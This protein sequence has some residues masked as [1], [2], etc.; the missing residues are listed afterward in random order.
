M[1]KSFAQIFLGGLIVVFCLAGAAR[2]VAA[3]QLQQARVSQV[4]QDVRLM[5][6]HGAPRPAAVNDT[7]T[8]RM[9]VRTGVES[10]AELTFTDLTLTRLGANTI[11]SFKQGARELDLTS[12]AVLLEVPPKAPAVK[13][14]TSAVTAAV[15]G[16]TALFATGPPT[17]FMVLEG[18]GT[19]Y[20]KGHPERAVIVHGGEMMMMTSEGRMTKPQKFD[21][22]LVLETSGL[23]QDFPP[24]AN[25]PLILA[26][27]NLQ[28]AEQQLA[29]PN[30]SLARSLVDVIGTTDQNVNTNPVVLVSNSSPTAPPLS[31]T[32]PPLTP[33]P[34]PATPTPPPPTPTPPPPTPTV[35]PS[36]TPT[37]FGTPSTINS[38]NPYVIT[39]GTL[40]TTD[41]SITT[42][43]V[44]DY[45]K[46][47][48]GQ[49]TD[50]AFSAWAFGSTSGFDTGS[51]FDGLIGAGSA[52]AF[53]FAALQLTG[54]PII[55]TTNGETNLALIAVDGIT[56]GGPGAVLTFEGINGLL[57]AT[58]NGA[59]TL[60]SE[61]SFSG[62]HDLTIY[63]RGA[64]SDLTLGS[65]ISTTNQVSLFAERDMSLASNIT[66]ENLY[67]FVGRNVSISGEGAILAPTITLLA[68][69]NLNWTGQISDETAFNSNGNVSISAGQ[70]I[71]V[72][73]DL[74]I[75]RRNGGITSG[76]NIVLNA[77]T[78]LLV[79]G[80]LSIA[81]D[82]SNLTAGANIDVFTGRNLTV[83]GSLALQTS[84]TA[85]S[86]TGANIEVLVGGDLIA[87]DLFLG[88]EMAVQAPQES[89]ENLTLS[90]GQDLIAH[91]TANTGGID[92]EIITPV[93]QT[94]NSGANLF[95]NV[96]NNLT[97]DA[98]GD[99]TL[100]I[101]NNINHVVNGANILAA[102]GGNLNTNNLTLQLLNNGG[103][104][105]TGGIVSLAVSGNITSRGAAIF[106]I[107]NGGG[108]MDQNTAIAVAATNLSANSLSAQIDNREGGVIGGTGVIE[109]D[110]AG[111][112]NIANDATIAFYGSN[113]AAAS[114]I[115]INGGNYNVGGTFLNYIDGNG[116]ITFNNASAHAD[117]LKAGVFG[118]NG[119]LNIGGGTL[120]ADTTL[121]LYA[122]GSNGQLNFVSNVTLGGN[123][124]KILAANSI[125]IF[126]NVVVTVGGELAASVYTNNANYSEEW[127]G[128]G[129]TTG[130]FAGAGAKRPRPLSEAPPFDASP[131]R[132]PTNGKRMNNVININNS[133]QLLSLLD[134]AVLGP[135]GRVRVPN[136]HRGNASTDRLN[137]NRMIK[138]D[139]DTA[140][141]RRMR[142]RGVINN[143]PG[144]GTRAF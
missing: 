135:D 87:G 93:R 127:G 70:T 81:T 133:G 11:F 58:Q 23:I 31:P 117:I 44:T 40:I 99:T 60:G 130:T 29:G 34:P 142:D 78:D 62:L 42:N 141:V 124:S 116:A 25:L 134:G 131:P 132:N 67:A 8:E 13:V 100:F 50:G 5:E 85:Q 41:P 51:G 111:N 45:G 83:G 72:A 122:P 112:A 55:D 73:N 3:D 102:I 69:Q 98:A 119:V 109:M 64:I 37:K 39:S 82:I 32:P 21:V 33:T 16:G 97:T 27:V 59:I 52:A 28:L 128:N 61:I 121:K 76:L 125:T 1:K 65:D 48:R 66:T 88:V 14:S 46:I 2:F 140:D 6:A 107:Q 12:G 49:S 108:T 137:V 63:A 22:K 103:E 10:R 75:I 144:S 68:G 24:L 47:Y 104:I 26:V 139:R 77:G 18:T 9:G 129:S 143:R 114:A 120:S 96:G 7:V 53:K 138:A 94:V 80:D 43:G 4:I 86:G 56:S 106:D 74:T 101:N 126:D 118:A 54:D 71:N 110:I 136:H 105:G 123:S 30:Q 17:K 15:T 35:S 113:G 57:L 95:L 92:L 90:V 36:G 38:P 115:L 84:T 91:N 89:G 19:F 20:P 79:G